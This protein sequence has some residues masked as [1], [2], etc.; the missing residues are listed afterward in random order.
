M[1]NQYYAIIQ[2]RQLKSKHGGDITEISMVGVKDRILYRTYVDSFNRNYSLWAPIIHNPLH[3]YLLTGIKIKSST[4]ALVN[5]DS[6]VQ[7]IFETTDNTELYSE[8]VAAWQKQDKTQYQ[9]LFE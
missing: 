4:K 3:G 9:E 8:I 1:S 7:V 5:A 2:Q 6:A